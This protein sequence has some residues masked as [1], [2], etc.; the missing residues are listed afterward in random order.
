VIA[1]SSPIKTSTKVLEPRRQLVLAT[2]AADV[3]AAAGSSASS[4]DAGAAP[5][6][7]KAKTKAAE[8]WIPLI[9]EA[10][11]GLPT[12]PVFLKMQITYPVLNAAI[13]RLNAF[14]TKS[15]LSNLKDETYLESFSK[16]E[17]NQIVTS[18]EYG[19]ALDANG[20]PIVFNMKV[21][22][23]GL[24]KLKRLDVSNEN[25]VTVY[26]VKRFY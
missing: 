12:T 9:T 23:L 6:V 2:T 21:I 18:S 13:N 15:V 10:E 7:S 22:A 1:F 19:D 17:M 25:G 20:A 26:K 8:G 4:V 3:T 24:V 14:V 11:W 5:A 16:D